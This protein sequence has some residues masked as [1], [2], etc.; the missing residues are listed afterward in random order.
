[1]EVTAWM[2]P[3]PRSREVL[4]VPAG[5]GPQRRSKNKA[6]SFIRVPGICLCGGD[7]DGGDGGVC[8]SADS[9]SAEV[10]GGAGGRVPVGFGPQRRRGRPNAS[11]VWFQESSENELGSSVCRSCQWDLVQRRSNP[12]AGGIGMA[13][14]ARMEVI[15]FCGRNQRRGDRERC[16]LRA[17]GILFTDSCNDS[18]PW[19]SPV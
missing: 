8:R 17:G 5:F 11:G 7:K 14:A 19:F 3:A 13:E 16:R 9:I 15:C 1:M 18:G 2:Q 12:C 10:T 6:R 4:G